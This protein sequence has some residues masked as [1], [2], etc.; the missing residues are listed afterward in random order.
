MADTPLYNTILGV[1]CITQPSVYQ[2][3]G[4]SFELCM[5]TKGTLLS[6]PCA[7]GSDVEVCR[8][9]ILQ[10]STKDTLCVRPAL[11]SSL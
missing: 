4:E 10:H 7:H 11:T 2:R 1:Y 8:S 5:S 6:H 9:S 3:R